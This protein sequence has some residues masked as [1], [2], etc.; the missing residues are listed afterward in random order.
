MPF[1][2]VAQAQRTHSR[3]CCRWLRLPRAERRGYFAGFWRISLARG[4]RS[5]KPVTETSSPFT[6]FARPLLRLGVASNEGSAY[7]TALHVVNSSATCKGC[8]GG[9]LT[10]RFRVDAFQGPFRAI[11]HAYA[12][13]TA[14][15]GCRGPQ[16]VWHL[17]RDQVTAKPN[18]YA[19]RTNPQ[20]TPRP[21]NRMVNT[22]P[23][24]AW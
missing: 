5:P 16:R 2:I 11:H 18:P 21:T 12:R 1:S 13:V 10:A 22:L 7:N 20:R 15:L 8:P 17:T 24:R 14:T 9:G 23:R 4:H 3:Q 19:L 6:A